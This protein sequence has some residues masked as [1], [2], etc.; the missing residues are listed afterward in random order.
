MIRLNAWINVNIT[1]LRLINTIANG[2]H[3]MPILDY[4]NFLKIVAHLI[5][6]IAPIVSTQMWDVKQKLTQCVM[7]QEI[8]R[9]YTKDILNW[10]LSLYAFILFSIQGNIID[11]S[12]NI[13]SIRYCMEVCNGSNFGCNWISYSQ[14]K[15]LCL[16]LETCTLD[17]TNE[18]FISAHAS[19]G[20]PPIS[21]Q[22]S[23]FY[24]KI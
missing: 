3:L 20:A 8:V 22:N 11:F 21:K 23:I 10:N 7:F 5:L 17:K 12:H 14:Q 16:Y 18:D 1:F 13:P 24:G 19:C 2:S 15:Q 6:G 9:Y 4:V